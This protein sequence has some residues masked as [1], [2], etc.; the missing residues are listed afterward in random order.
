M[1]RWCAALLLLAACGFAAA[2]DPA[3]ARKRGCMAIPPRPVLFTT[4][5]QDPKQAVPA[6]IGLSRSWE[7][8]GDYDKA[9]EVVDAGLRT[10]PED[11]DLLAR[12]AELQYLRGQ[13]AE[14]LKTA[15]AA[16]AKRDDQFLA[17]S[18]RAKVYRDTGELQ[19]AD[20][21]FRWFVRTYTARDR[22]RKPITDPDT[23]L[24]VAE[25]GAENARWH[26]LSDQFRF[27][28]NEVYGDALKGDPD[29][30]PAEYQAGMLL[31]E[32]YNRGQATTAFDKALSINPRAAE[33][34]SARA[35][36]PCNN[37]N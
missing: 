22:A 37:W 20:T 35:G 4:L 8:D 9:A 16:I 27:I 29:L 6:A 1:R 26:N 14:A 13:F 3:E 28:L 21:E 5:V 31:L 17:R 2:A 33:R 18:V 25:A 12:R 11:P 15:D 30:W 23:L 10:S 32:K 36:P 34:W 24:L 7:C 19:K